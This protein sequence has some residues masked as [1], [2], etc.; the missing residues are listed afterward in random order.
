MVSRRFNTSGSCVPQIPQ[1]DASCKI[2]SPPLCTSL[3]TSLCVS[4]RLSTSLYV[5]LR[6]STSLHVSSRRFTHH[7]TNAQ[8]SSPIPTGARNE[9]ETRADAEADLKRVS[10]QCFDTY[11]PKSLISTAMKSL[12]CISS[13]ILT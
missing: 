11:L 10:L 6:L 2:I 5:S 7:L 4:L 13:K 1:T 9:V 12:C 3:C 8:I